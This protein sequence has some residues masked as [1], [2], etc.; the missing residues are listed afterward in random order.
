MA[1]MQTPGAPSAP[2]DL[3][4][5]AADADTVINGSTQTFVEDVIEASMKQPVIVDF[6]AT[7]CGPCKTL[8]PII[9]K[10]VRDTKG[11]V[12]LVKIDVDRNQEIAQQLRIQSIPAVY[13]FSG[14]RP[15]DGFVGALPESQ[16]KTFIQRLI[17]TAGQGGDAAAAIEEAL[18]EAKSL[19][20][21][22]DAAS[23]LEIYQSVMGED[24][25]N[26]VAAAGTLRALIA[27][28]HTD[29]AK[30]LLE[31]LPPEL[32]KHADVV[33]VKTSMELAAEA[34]K[35]GPTDEL[36]KRVA[37]DANDHQARFDLAS[38]QFAAG[39][40]EAAID[41]LLELFRRNRSWNEEAARKQLVK[42]FEAMGPV[43]ELT[44][45]GRKR[46]SSLMFS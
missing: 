20:D 1:F 26:A 18:T 41:Q 25:A 44:V 33:A 24:P 6:W 15:V 36:E 4:G 7:W 11:A 34:S 5:P 9:E 12:K 38:A 43:D 39:Q 13:A 16:V 2:G 10:A 29:E 19:L 35:A 22:G 28:G 27:L 8:G 30:T 45:A 23:A 42:F 21:S 40:R 31:S 37:A 17:A 46:L 14:G 3:G 32:A